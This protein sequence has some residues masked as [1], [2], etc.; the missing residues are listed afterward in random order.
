MSS[1]PSQTYEAKAPKLASLIN[2]NVSNTENDMT[3]T[4]CKYAVFVQLYLCIWKKT[5]SGMH[6][7]LI[8]N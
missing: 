8:E 4:E 5:C 7:G 3:I 2:G 1:Y 6:V